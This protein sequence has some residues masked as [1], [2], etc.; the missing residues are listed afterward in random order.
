MTSE[1]KTRPVGNV[2]TLMGVD[3]QK[4]ANGLWYLIADVMDCRA[5]DPAKRAEL[6]L[7]EWT[8]GIRDWGN[9]HTFS[10]VNDASLSALA[11]YVAVDANYMLRRT[12]VYQAALQYKF[13]PVMGKAREN[14]NMLWQ[15]H[16]VDP[17][18][19]R[20]GGGNKK[21]MLAQ[22][23]FQSDTLDF[24]AVDLITCQLPAIRLMIPTPQ[25]PVLS[26]HLQSTCIVDGAI[27]KRWSGQHVD[28]HL[29][30]CLKYILLLAM[31][32]QLIPA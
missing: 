21:N 10:Q 30:D 5:I 26:R 27:E 25:D 14:F 3:V 20:R 32:L 1:Q 17:F 11:Q 12:E 2:T 29:Y 4:V 31:Y 22:L 19:G 7:G 8:I 18:E 15:R 6:R 13:I 24:K 28:D 16:N 9:V 23:M